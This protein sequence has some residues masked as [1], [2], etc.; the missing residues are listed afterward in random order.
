MDHYGGRANVKSMEESQSILFGAARSMAISLNPLATVKLASQT[1][2][3][4]VQL[5]SVSNLT[6]QHQSFLYIMG[7]IQDNGH[8]AR[9]AENA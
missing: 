9:R 5:T 1:T 7:L 6:V 8:L 2:L 4:R 3:L